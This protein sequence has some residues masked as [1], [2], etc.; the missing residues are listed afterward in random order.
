MNELVNVKKRADRLPKNHER[1]GNIPDTTHPN[2]SKIPEQRSHQSKTREIKRHR[3]VIDIKRLQT[4]QRII[5]WL[6]APS[7][8][9]PSTFRLGRLQEH[10]QKQSRSVD[11]SRLEKGKAKL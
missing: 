11:S 3:T 10:Q 4:V 2:S 9:L 8:E 1:D 6:S 5:A 7:R